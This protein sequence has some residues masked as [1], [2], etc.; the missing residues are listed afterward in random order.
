[1]IA[2]IGRQDDLHSEEVILHGRQ[3]SKSGDVKGARTGATSTIA[4]ARS[5]ATASQVSDCPVRSIVHL[6]RGHDG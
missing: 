2:L 6:G 5:S 3:Q 1:M 4:V